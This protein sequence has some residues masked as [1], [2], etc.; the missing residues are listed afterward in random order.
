MAANPS[1]GVVRS[2]CRAHDVDN[3]YVAGSSVFPTAGFVNPTATLLA[4]SL[5]LADQLK[6]FNG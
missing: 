5:R 1:D 3:L 6:G 4:L 2:D